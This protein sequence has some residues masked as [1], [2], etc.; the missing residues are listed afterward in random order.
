MFAAI[1]AFVRLN[2]RVV[3]FGALAAAAAVAVLWFAAHERA[4]GRA[5][6]E[7]EDAAAVAA[8]DARAAKATAAADARRQTDA[9]T[10][11]DT[12]E[13]LSHADDAAPDS[14]PSAA[15]R[16]YLC[17]VLRHQQ[18]GGPSKLPAACGPGGPAGAA[19]QH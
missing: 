1:F 16:A 14:R 4:I 10:V 13:E 15:R 9:A 7:T 11:A 3:L 17:G 12:R 8:A 5:R 19:A 18:A 6:I 2:P